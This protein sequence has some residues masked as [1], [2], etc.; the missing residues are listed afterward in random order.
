MIRKVLAIVAATLFIAN[1]SYANLFQT[2][3]WSPNVAPFR[4]SSFY[5]GAGL[6]SSNLNYHTI[7]LEPTP[8]IDTKLYGK[9]VLGNIQAGYQANYGCYSL[10]IDAFANVTSQRTSAFSIYGPD[11]GR[12]NM[13]F[14]NDWNAGVSALPGYLLNDFL[15]AFLRLGYI[16]SH[17]EINVSANNSYH[18]A[19][20]LSGAEIGLGGEV[21]FPMLKNFSVRGEFDSVIAP[22]WNSI[23][24]FTCTKN[25]NDNA[26]VDISNNL[27]QIN[28]IYHIV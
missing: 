2:G 17:Y 7:I 9:G 28:F 3:H 21:W 20:N 22:R 8:T 27:F 19:K 12:R 11:G 26:N 18:F 10:A 6:G 1:P 24:T 16:N 5:A 25:C 15:I 14:I 4:V 23:G 13:Q